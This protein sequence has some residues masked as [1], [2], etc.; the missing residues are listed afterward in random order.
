MKSKAKG[1]RQMSKGKREVGFAGFLW[2]VFR[3]VMAG[4]Y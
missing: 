3:T 2:N 4:S 1:K